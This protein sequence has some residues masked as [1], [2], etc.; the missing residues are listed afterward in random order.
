MKTISAN[1]N[2]SEKVKA[3]TTLRV[4]GVSLPPFNSLNLGEHVGD[5]PNHVSQN[6]SQLKTSLALP[7]PPL[8][9]NQTHS[10]IVINADNYHKGI[11]ADAIVTDKANIVLAIM[12]ADCLPILLSNKNGDWLAAIHA[13]WRGFSH[14]LIDKTINTYPG[15]PN[16][17]IAWLGPAISKTHFEVGLEVKKKLCRNSKEMACFLSH[18]QKDKAYLDLNTLATYRLNA[19]GITQIYLSNQC[20]YSQEKDYFSYRRENQTGRIAT[21]IYRSK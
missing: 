20:T 15:N 9:L 4:G 6:R 12:T 14:D 13:G 7:S 11:T 8:W 16:E 1:W 3:L 21:L 19:L 2:I 17:I 18:R 5:L 10:D